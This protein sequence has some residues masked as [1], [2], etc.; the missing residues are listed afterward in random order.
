VTE[1]LRLSDA[2]NRLANGMWGGLSRPVPVQAVKQTEQRASVGYGSWREY[3]AEYFRTAALR[4]ELPI[5]VVV[6]A[7]RACENQ[8]LRKHLH[9]SGPTIVPQDIL[10]R[11][12]ISHRGL[13][14]HAIR[15]TPK[16]TGG[17]EILCALLTV[18]V[19]VVYQGDFDRW[20]RSERRKRKWASQASSSKPRKGRPTKRTAALKNAVLAL[21]RDDAWNGKHT[22]AKLRKCR[23]V[24]ALH[25]EKGE[26]GLSRIARIGRSRRNASI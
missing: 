22:F 3:A 14:D 21:V 13:P 19:L 25:R 18:G 15:P 11:L 4:G 17:D 12:I 26:P 7:E 20:Y 10:S 2:V 6:D 24:R 8:P 23:L 5:Y 16:T 9:R 1:F